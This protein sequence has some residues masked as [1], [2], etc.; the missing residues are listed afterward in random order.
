MKVSFI[1]TVY[2][3]EDNIQ[4]LL[5]SLY[6]QTL[7][8]AEIIITDG[9]SIDNTITALSSLPVPA[10]KPS[11]TLLR[12]KG[13]RS[14]GRNAAIDQ[15]TGEIIVISD[16]GCILDKNWIK[17]I[18]QPFKDTSIDVVA[19]YYKGLA[20]NAFQKCLIPYVLV[21]PDKVNAKTFLPATRSMALRKDI[22]RD[23][24]MFAQEYSHN[25]DYVFAQQLKKKRKKI[26]FAKDAVVY[27]KPPEKVSEAF[28][29]FYR[30]AY[31]DV[32]AGILR[33]KVVII[34]L[35]Y[36]LGVLLLIGG[37]RDQRFWVVGGIGAVI[38]VT[39]SIIKNYRYV[40]DFRALFFLP[41]FQFVSDI[42]VLRGTAN[43]IIRR[44][45][46]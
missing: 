9:G 1:A 44:K 2:N 38:Y 46:N 21:M 34:F 23:I 14:V 36:S 3:E 7:T 11:V 4:A 18:T 17:N 12:K 39:W 24:G 22:W 32:E 27:W 40:Q 37:F 19:G 25:E 31:G 30:F 6:S 33:P 16:A 20:K 42:A 15:A 43:G 26:V 13:N 8:P 29:M 45:L 35:R 10:N 41:L 28:T 5:Q